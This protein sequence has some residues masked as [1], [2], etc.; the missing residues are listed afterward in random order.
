MGISK[1]G[2]KRKG[3]GRKPAPEHLKR[4]RITIRLPNELIWWLR[5]RKQQGRTIEEALYQKMNKDNVVK[6]ARNF[7]LKAHG[8]QMYGSE[9]YENRH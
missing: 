2:G 8:D 7:A 6:K 5:E 1:R 9:P 4:E 3:A